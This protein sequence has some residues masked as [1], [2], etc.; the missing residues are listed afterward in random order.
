M[1]IREL[2]TSVVTAVVV[3][4][5]KRRMEAMR[6]ED[7]IMQALVFVTGSNFHVQYLPIRALT[8]LIHFGWRHGRDCS[9]IPLIYN[10]EYVRGLAVRFFLLEAASHSYRTPILSSIINYLLEGQTQTEL[11]DVR[12]VTGGVPPLLPT[13]KL[14]GEMVVVSVPWLPKTWVGSVTVTSSLESTRRHMPK[15]HLA[16]LP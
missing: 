9:R 1:E 3:G 10:V 12:T 13:L 7:A 6:P 14:T 16:S 4:G 5:S 15:V 11:C 2:H 8:P